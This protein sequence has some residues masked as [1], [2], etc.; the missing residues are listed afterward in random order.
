MTKTTVICQEVHRARKSGRDCIAITASL[1]LGA[2]LKPDDPDFKI[3]AL[4]TAKVALQSQGLRLGAPVLPSSMARN[5][6]TDAV[7]KGPIEICVPGDKA[8]NVSV[9]D[10]MDIF[11]LSTGGCIYN[12]YVFDTRDDLEW[13][14][15]KQLILTDI[16]QRRSAQALA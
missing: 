13:L 5:S 14:V 1:N 7:P 8:R 3:K 10:Q 16:A 11:E 6:N 4:E 12:L 2:F 15:G 9:V